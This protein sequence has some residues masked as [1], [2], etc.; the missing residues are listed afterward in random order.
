M[1]ILEATDE[2]IGRAAAVIRNGGV[3]AYPTETVYGIGCIPG[4]K[5]ASQR[6]CEI[7]AR[8]DNPLPLICS[9]VNVACKVVDFNVMAD[10]LAEQFWPGPLILVLKSKMKYGMWV[11]HGASTLGVRVSSHPVASKLA[12]L[13]EGVIVGSSVDIDGKLALTAKDALEQFGRKVDMILD[14]GPCPGSERST[15]LDLSSDEL[16]IIRKGP[17]TGEQIREALK[18]LPIDD[19]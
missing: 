5:D 16:W 18:D 17:I 10:R 14:G 3:V 19:S 6:V 13:S 15:V 11:T 12:K 8:A 9:D 4:D 7:K 1:K 2:N